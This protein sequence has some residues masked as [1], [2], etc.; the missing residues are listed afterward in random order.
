MKEFHTVPMGNV[1][2][3][4]R[5]RE[6]AMMHLCHQRGF[7]IEVMY[8]KVLRGG[9]AAAHTLQLDLSGRQELVD[10]AFSFLARPRNCPGIVAGDLGVGLPTVHAYIRSA[11]LQDI[12]QTHCINRQTFHTLFRSAKPS[13]RCTSINTDSPRMIAHQVEINSGDEHPTAEVIH[14]SN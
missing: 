10:T 6:Y 12:V 4:L 3:S 13:V 9:A 2:S 14:R 7:E 11:A 5:H 8:V 1:H